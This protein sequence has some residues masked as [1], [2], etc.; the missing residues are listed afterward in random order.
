MPHNSNS[1]SETWATPK[2]LIEKFK[3]HGLTKKILRILVKI[4]SLTHGRLIKCRKEFSGL[5]INLSDVQAEIDAAR[6][7]PGGQPYS[8]WAKHPRF[9]TPKGIE[10]RTTRSARDDLGLPWSR[11]TFK[12]GR[13]DYLS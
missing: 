6:A 3:E 1:V 4:G 11:Q 10:Y 2:A 7:R 8:D 13:F 5:V 9:V 12:P